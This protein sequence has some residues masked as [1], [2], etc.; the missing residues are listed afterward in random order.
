MTAVMDCLKSIT[1]SIRV[2][3]AHQTEDRDIGLR[4]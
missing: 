4:G 2:A 1:E 3:K